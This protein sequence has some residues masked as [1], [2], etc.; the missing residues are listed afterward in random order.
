M[1]AKKSAVHT[2]TDSRPS[3]KLNPLAAG[4]QTLVQKGDTAYALM[5]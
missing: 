5:I 3:R 1:I 4:I 2:Q